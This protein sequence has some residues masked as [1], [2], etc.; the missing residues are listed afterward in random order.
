M[1]EENKAATRRIYDIINSGD[2]SGVDDV[3]AADAVDHEAPPGV[4]ERGSAALRAFVE[5]FRGAFPD[6][7]VTIDD[8]IT[9]GDRVAVRSTAT[10][11]H[12]G[13]F[14]G[15]PPTG[16]QFTVGGIDIVR[17]AGGKAVEH[18]GAFDNMA[19]LQQLG[20]APGPN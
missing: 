20:V 12:K 15:I 9:E 17:F 3:I 1:S 19:L 4:S 7:R 18:R 5:I 6:L 13:D 11:T 2:L 10:G 8:M 16:K 14:Q